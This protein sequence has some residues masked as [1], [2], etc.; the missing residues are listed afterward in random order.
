MGVSGD[1]SRAQEDEARAYF[2]EHG[3]WPG[4]E[5]PRRYVPPRQGS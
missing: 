1:R 4:E 5:A 3:H 2:A